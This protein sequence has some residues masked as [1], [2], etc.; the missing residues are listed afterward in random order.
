MTVGEITR[1]SIDQWSTQINKVLPDHPDLIVLP[2]VCDRPDVKLL[3]LFKRKELIEGQNGEFLERLRQIALEHKTYIAYPTYC[4]DNFGNLRNSL[5]VIDRQGELLGTY[6]KN[7]LVS[8][9]STDLGVHYSNKPLILDL[10]FGRVGFVICFDLNFSEL[11]QEYK[12]LGPELMVFSSEYHG[13]L[14]QNYWAYALRSYFVGCIRPPALSTIVS[15]LGE[16]IAHTTNYFSHIT[17]EINLDYFIVHLDGHWNK[18]EAM[19]SKYGPEVTIYDPGNL[20]SVLVS[21]ESEQLSAAQLIKE[22]EFE[23]LDEYLD[24]ARRHR[25]ENLE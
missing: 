11:L 3:S 2:E 14:M 22:F 23:L 16:T 15:P 20:G 12:K 13:G 17:K 4:R 19:K 18:L 9:E 24:R 21:I 7:F 10:D 1:K 6:H 8:E 25:K 5:H